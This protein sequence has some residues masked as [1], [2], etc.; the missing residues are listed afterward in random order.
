VPESTPAGR[1]ILSRKAGKFDVAVEYF[2]IAYEGWKIVE[3]NTGKNALYCLLNI[4]QC[5]YELD[6]LTSSLPPLL[7]VVALSRVR[8]LGTRSAV[9]PDI[10]EYLFE[11]L[12][13]LA[14]CHAK[15]PMFNEAVHYFLESCE[16]GNNYLQEGDP[17]VY[18]VQQQ[19]AMYRRACDVLRRRKH[20]TWKTSFTHPLHPQHP[21]VAS[22]NNSLGFRCDICGVEGI[23][24]RY[25]CKR[26]G[27]GQ[28]TRAHCCD[29]DV[30]IGCCSQ[31]LAESETC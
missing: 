9:E 4:G 11:S 25:W 22:E 21:L 24:F 14:L 5:Y 6:V 16:A 26:C 7:E 17:R 3:A 15:I 13:T 1:C 27:D 23:G 20:E 18:R 31:F 10:G 12:R 8:L 19:V 2:K 29:I 28:E 30:C